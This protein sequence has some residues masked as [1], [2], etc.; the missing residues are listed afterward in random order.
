MSNVVEQI[1]NA[2]ESTISTELGSTYKELSHKYNVLKN[3]SRDNDKMYGVV[4]LGGDGNTGVVKKV[5]LDQVFQVILTHGY[6]DR[7]DSSD[8][9]EK[10]LLL[11]D[12]ISEI[13]KA[14]YNKKL[15]IPSVVLVVSEFT[16]NEP[17]FE[18]GNNLIVLR[19][20]FTIKYREILD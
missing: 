1:I 5:T 10:V 20:D 2:F 9:E 7:D 6:I 15:G 17:E 4:P 3:H 16:I 11:F 19:T 8:K 14:A 13:Y 18:E 12:K